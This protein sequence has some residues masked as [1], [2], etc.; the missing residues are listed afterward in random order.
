MKTAEDLAELAIL[1]SRLPF[2]SDTP[3]ADILHKLMDVRLDAAKEGMRRAVEMMHKER[4][5]NPRPQFKITERKILAA[6]E[7][8]TEK[9]L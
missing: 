4:C 1:I 5:I 2:D 3:T 8:L 7:Q 9:N 6:A